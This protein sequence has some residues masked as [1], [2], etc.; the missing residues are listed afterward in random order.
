MKVYVVTSG[1]YSEYHIEAIFTNRSAAEKFCNLDFN[2]EIEEYETDS[3]EIKTSYN[4]NVYYSVEKGKITDIN[5]QSGTIGIEET[6][7]CGQ[8]RT[9]VNISE[10]VFKDIY[11]HGIKSEMLLK[12]VQDKWA[13]YKYEHEDEIK[14]E[15][16]P[17]IITLPPDKAAQVFAVQA[18]YLNA[19]IAMKAKEEN[20]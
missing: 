1:H 8:Y 16:E 7:C 10:K 20:T 17:E 18:A 11:E 12:I 4:A 14:K 15:E 5:T 6:Y 3:V 19:R 2:R 9:S 13:Q